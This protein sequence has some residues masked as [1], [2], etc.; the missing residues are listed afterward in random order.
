MPKT[1]VRQTSL[2]VACL[3]SMATAAPEEATLKVH[4]PRRV[5][6]ED[7]SVQLGQI[8]GLRGEHAL[9][10][11]ASRIP[12]GRLFSPS[13]TL[14]FTRAQILS[15]LACC[16]FQD[17]AINVTGADQTEVGRSSTQVKG[18]DL[19]VL[20]RR[21]AEQI[22][23]A[24]TPTVLELVR[25]PQDLALEETDGKVELIPVALNGA[26]ATQ[27]RIRISVLIDGVEKGSRDVVFRLKHQRQI[28]IAT[29]PLALG[30]TLSR[31]NTRIEKRLG[32]TVQ[33]VGWQPPYGAV[34]RR[35]IPAGAEVQPSWLRKA[36]ASVTLK[37]ND[38]VVIRIER[39]G[40]LITAM[41]SVLTAGHTGQHIKVKNL[42]SN[43]I[44]LCRVQEDGSVAPIL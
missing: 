17:I 20:A 36:V 6:L 34:V 8:C 40:L 19:V 21:Y 10:E 31:E 30:Q 28:L 14:T 29:Q 16:G 41:G 44:I 26:S 3:V 7:S 39:P 15:R 1:T 38:A 35:A 24:A 33:P 27:R 42:D 12:L 11:K 13:Q 2:I 43:R 18:E 9:V 5:A 4:M 25:V 32:T 22:T 23:P 37:R